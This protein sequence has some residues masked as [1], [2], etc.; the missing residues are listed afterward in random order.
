[1]PLEFHVQQAKMRKQKQRQFHMM[2][3]LWQALDN[4]IGWILYFLAIFTSKLVINNIEQNALMGY[5]LENYLTIEKSC[6]LPATGKSKSLSA[7][8]HHILFIY[9]HSQ[10]VC[11]QFFYCCW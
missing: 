7:S 2:A 9:M 11:L 3:P 4:G 1:M 10:C 6:L 8:H 5:L